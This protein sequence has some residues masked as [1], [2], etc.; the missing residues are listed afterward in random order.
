MIR[1]PTTRRE[2]EIWEA[3]NLLRLE[4]PEIKDITGDRIMAK[5][6]SLNYKKGCPNEI[7]KYRK[8]WWETTGVSVLEARGII[9]ST[10]RIAALEKQRV[11]DAKRIVELIKE[12]KRLE[13]ALTELT[14]FLKSNITNLC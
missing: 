7:Y 12:R 11:E 1:H 8:T 5:L 3:C 9:T 2:R 14:I 10:E 13:V 4:Y 6:L